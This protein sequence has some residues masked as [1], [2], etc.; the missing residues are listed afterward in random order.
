MAKSN[1]FTSLFVNFVNNIKRYIFNSVNS[2]DII[3]IDENTSKSQY[4][5]ARR[6]LQERLIK[7]KKSS[8]FEL[9]D[10]FDDYLVCL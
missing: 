2:N 7:L 1:G 4:S 6:W 8:S 9:F 3:K 5:R 10:L